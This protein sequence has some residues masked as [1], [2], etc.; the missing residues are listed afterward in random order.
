MVFVQISSNVRLNDSSIT[1]TG[2][3]MNENL[4]TKRIV[5]QQ[6]EVDI[7]QSNAACPQSHKFDKMK[8][9]FVYDVDVKFTLSSIIDHLPSIIEKYKIFMG[10]RDDHADRNDILFGKL[11]QNMLRRFDYQNIINLVFHIDG[12]F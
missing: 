9:H 8:Q 12:T 1:I 10:K 7:I 3:G 2:T 4:F 11:C 5:C 6:C